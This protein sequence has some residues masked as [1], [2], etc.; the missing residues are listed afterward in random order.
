MLHMVTFIILTI[1]QLTKIY[2][3]SPSTFYL[4]L[5][6]VVFTF[7]RLGIMFSSI[8]TEYPVSHI[9]TDL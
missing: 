3:L 7:M 4:C 2:R 6:L 9:P 1:Y 8:K 5:I